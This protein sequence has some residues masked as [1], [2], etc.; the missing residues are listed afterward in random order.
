MR[1]RPHPATLST[2]RTLLYVP[3]RGTQMSLELGQKI[4]I[5]LFGMRLSGL[6]A[7]DAR[8]EG[9]I[10]ALGPGVITVQLASYDGGLTEV[11][12]SPGR[13]ER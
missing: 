6:P 8:A 9:T 10:V 13:I 3:R 4:E 5:D 1:E 12:V 7:G 2:V 11:T